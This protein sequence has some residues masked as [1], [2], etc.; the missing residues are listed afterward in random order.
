MS[1]S[2]S[3]SGSNSQTTHGPG[4]NQTSASSSIHNNSSAT[5]P[6]TGSSFGAAV[7]P[8][9]PSSPR[10]VAVPV[11]VR[12]GKTLV[13]VQ[14]AQ[15]DRPIHKLIPSHSLLHAV[16]DTRLLSLSIPFS[17][18]SSKLANMTETESLTD[19]LFHLLLLFL[20]VLQ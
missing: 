14:T 10:K 15:T 4:V 17:S 20:F 3:S 2:T 5:A 6:T 19:A 16:I 8:G 13:S 9:P 18:L 7:P 1:E 11:L 12:D